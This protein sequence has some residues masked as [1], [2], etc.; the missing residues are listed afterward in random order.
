MAARSLYELTFDDL[1]AWFAE[2]GQPHFRA[3]QVFEWAYRRNAARFDE[4]T[5]LPRDLRAVLDESF[6][7]GPP[8]VE[9]VTEGGETAK[10]LLTLPAGGQVECVRIRMGG[11]HTACLSTQVGCAV[12]CAFCATGRRGRERDLSVGEIISQMIALRALPAGDA[13]EPPRVSNV[14]FMGMGE[15]FH[16]YDATVAAVR[17]LSDKHAFGMSPSRITVATAGVARMISRYANEG[18]ATELAV[19]LN[20]PDDD[21]RRRLMPG[22]ARWPLEEVLAACREF[23]EAQGGRPVTFTYVLIEGVTDLLDHARA[24]ARLL[25]RQPHHVNI[26]PLNPVGHT[27]LRAPTKDRTNAFVHH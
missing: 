19:S 4:M 21:L 16:N 14:V 15:P 17:M 8:P 5:N 18:L 6:S 1:A 2:R 23:T 3:R 10:L 27:D 26:I 9:A 13:A 20:A 12:R 22:V 24:L 11:A 7:I 25:R